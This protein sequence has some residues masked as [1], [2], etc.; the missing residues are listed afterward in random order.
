MEVSTD[1]FTQVR[2]KRRRQISPRSESEKTGDN[3][4]AI[5][6]NSEDKLVLI[7]S[8]TDF[9]KVNPIRLSRA[10]Q[11]HFAEVRLHVKAFC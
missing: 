5:T 11:A 10:L 3:S 9:N 7:I 4:A 2:K 6:S 1:G 8:G